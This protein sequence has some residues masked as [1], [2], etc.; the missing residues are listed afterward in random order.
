M[1]KNHL[2]LEFYLDCAHYSSSTLTI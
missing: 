1:S 2:R